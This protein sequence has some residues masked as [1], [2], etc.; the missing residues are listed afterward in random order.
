[1]SS[2]LGTLR[3][4]LGAIKENHRLLF[5]A[6]FADLAQFVLGELAGWARSALMAHPYWHEAR[7]SVLGGEEPVLWSAATLMRAIMLIR[8]VEGVLVT[9]GYVLALFVTL[10]MLAGMRDAEAQQKPAPKR[11]IARLA[12]W[13][14]GLLFVFQ[15]IVF[16]AMTTGHFPGGRT[17]QVQAMFVSL[18]GGIVVAVLVTPQAMRL[19]AEVCGGAVGVYDVRAGRMLAVLCVMASVVV[20]YLVEPLM[21][22][23]PHDA[24]ST[25]NYTIA[26]L[27][28]SILCALPYGVLFVSFGLLAQRSE[29]QGR[30]Y[31][32]DVETP[33]SDG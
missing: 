32:P 3:R 20:M 22:L 11:E 30:A 16:A 17:S 9:F 10:R 19:S 18:V 28:R 25:M 5:P 2:V 31:T 29:R 24:Q 27:M 23:V 8:M 14:F 26:A 13:T 12:A 7:T 21:R 6:V 4:A 1:M 33:L 15:V